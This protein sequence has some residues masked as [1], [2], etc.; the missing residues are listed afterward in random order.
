MSGDAFAITIWYRKIVETWLVVNSRY[1]SWLDINLC[2][3]LGEGRDVLE[4][5]SLAPM[6]PLC[7]CDALCT[8]HPVDAVKMSQIG[9]CI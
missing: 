3:V 7:D 9:S 8:G 5:G 2:T 6:D 1:I 4:A